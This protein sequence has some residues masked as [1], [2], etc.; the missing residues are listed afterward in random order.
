MNNTEHKAK[1]VES[2]AENTNVEVEELSPTKERLRR[3][4]SIDHQLNGLVDVPKSKVE[5]EEIQNIKEV[6]YTTELDKLEAGLGQPLSEEVRDKIHKNM[7]N[8]PTEKAEEK[9]EQ[10]DRLMIEKIVLENIENPDFKNRV[11]PL[12]SEN[13]TQKTF[14]NGLDKLLDADIA[15]PK[16]DR[17]RL[18]KQTLEYYS[19]P[20]M[21]EKPLWHSTSSYTLRKCLEDGLSGGHGKFSG[22]AGSTNSSDQT[23]KGLSVSHPNYPSAET[24]Q[25]LFA[26]LSAKKKGLA[27]YLEI[28]S[29]KITGKTLPE[30]FVAELFNTTSHEEMR[31]ILAKR[32][33]MKTDQIDDEMIKKGISEE[34]QKAWIDY[35][36]KQEYPPIKEEIE[37][38]ILPT[39]SN[40]KLRQELQFEVNHPFPCMI[41]L[42]S[43][44]KEQH[45]TSVSRGE[46]ATHIPF[47][48]FYWDTFQGEDIREI[49]VPEN[50]TKKVSG[51]LEEKGLVGIKIVPLEIFEIKRVIQNSI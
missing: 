9:G 8:S 26:R 3:I 35:F 18:F 1:Q 24:F 25:Q 41:T 4:E 6:E 31:E 27:N 17:I 33:K 30:V 32:M 34:A 46:K 16:A 49:R 22:E 51:W 2:K 37:G 12:G 14:Q 47:E 50:Q 48:D 23:Q 43:S 39:I 38:K 20:V 29:E 28:D 44:G 11:F 19:S 36:N 10:Y 13:V 5:I 40:E 42:E 45:L 15:L 21:T 7:V